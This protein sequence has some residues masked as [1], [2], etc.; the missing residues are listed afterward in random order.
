MKLTGI[1]WGSVADWF[2]AFGT[3]GAVWIAL[4][5]R[6]GKSIIEIQAYAK[7]VPHM[8]SWG[9]IDKNGEE[10]YENHGD[11]LEIQIFI[12]NLGNTDALVTEISTHV[13]EKH[14]YNFIAK[15]MIVQSGSVSEISSDGTYGDPF[16]TPFRKYNLEF[17]KNNN[18][19]IIFKTHNGKT[20]KSKIIISA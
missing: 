15:P 17:I 11:K 8:I 6:K 4:Y 13:L 1:E 12:S 7:I 14:K 20:Y 2:A 9:E 10:I 5:L 16:E 3:I 19:Q 18:S